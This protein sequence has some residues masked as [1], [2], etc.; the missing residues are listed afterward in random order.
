VLFSF[1]GLYGIVD[2]M[3]D[4]IVVSFGVKCLIV[5]ASTP[6]IALSKKWGTH[7]SVSV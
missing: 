3:V 2:S 6:L 7:D 4:I 1:L 5:L